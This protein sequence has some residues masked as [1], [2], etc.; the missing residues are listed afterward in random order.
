MI[1]S[2]FHTYTRTHTRKVSGV[3]AGH[4][5]T[6]ACGNYFTMILAKDS[7]VWF[8]GR[9]AEG[10]FGDGKSIKRSKVFTKVINAGVTVVAA[11]EEFSMVIKTD[12][13]LS[14]TGKKQP[15][16]PAHPINLVCV[17]VCVC[18]CVCVCA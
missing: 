2:L 14:S 11:G 13:S 9:G 18:V 16:D 12:G 5:I 8:A 15:S 6:L 17:V 4:I 1:L 3:S 7:S 10:Q